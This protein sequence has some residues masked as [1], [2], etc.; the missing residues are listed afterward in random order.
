M[1]RRSTTE[2]MMRMSLVPTN[3]PNR[4]FAW[5]GDRRSFGTPSGEVERDGARDGAVA[6]PDGQRSAMRPLVE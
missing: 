2:C 6:A 4:V 3:G 5:R 1:P